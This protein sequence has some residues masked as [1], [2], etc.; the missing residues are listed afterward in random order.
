MKTKT[1]KIFLT[2]FTEI[3]FIVLFY[4]CAGTG[5]KTGGAGMM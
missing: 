5:V 2:V 3:I 4:G 1:K